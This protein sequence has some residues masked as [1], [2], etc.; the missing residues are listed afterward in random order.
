MLQL[1]VLASCW[2]FYSVLAAT[3]KFDLILSTDDIEQLPESSASNG[4]AKSASQFRKDWTSRIET[5]LGT[6]RQ[7]HVTKIAC[8][9]GKQCELIVGQAA[10][11]KVAVPTLLGNRMGA[12]L[13]VQ[14]RDSIGD[15]SVTNVPIAE[16]LSV[17]ENIADGNLGEE[18]SAKLLSS[19]FEYIGMLDLRLLEDYVESVSNSAAKPDSKDAD[20]EPPRK[21]NIALPIIG[22][23]CAAALCFCLC[24]LLTIKCLRKQSPSSDG[25]RFTKQQ[26]LEGPE[27]LTIM[28]RTDNPDIN[29]MPYPNVPAAPNIFERMKHDYDKQQREKE[30]QKR[31][32]SK[33][34]RQHNAPESLQWK[35]QHHVETFDPPERM[36]SNRRS[37][38]PHGK[39]KVR[40]GTKKSQRRNKE[41]SKRDNK[42]GQHKHDREETREKKRDRGTSAGQNRHNRKSISND[43]TTTNGT[44]TTTTSEG[45]RSEKETYKHSRSDS[46]SKKHEK[47]KSRRFALQGEI[48]M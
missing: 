33:G 1:A 21:N 24:A 28:G 26:W 3:L 12:I 20:A 40:S 17:F 31:W 43:T 22:S 2:F 14:M 23:V 36:R 19:G 34:A 45:M 9:L 13:E 7:V 4:P 47:R 6:T 18:M 38:K 39:K 35:G 25:T 16:M 5:S 27:D 8:C 30:A 46:N 15:P 48:L 29:Y 32:L 11:T 10:S 41:T 37:D 44:S 42:R